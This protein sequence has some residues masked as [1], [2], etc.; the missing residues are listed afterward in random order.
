MNSHG[1]NSGGH[2]KVSTA[3]K[4]A[5]TRKW[6]FLAVFLLVLFTSTGVLGAL[7]LLPESGGTE[8]AETPKPALTAAASLA[9]A[10][11]LPTKI[12]IPALDLEV[13]V[14][15]PTSTNV[16]VL[17]KALLNGTVRYPT[18]SKL[19]EA[20]NVII[21]GHS[22]YLPIVRNPSFKAFNHIEDLKKGDRIL[23]T[24]GARTFVY[25]VESVLS[26]DAEED[27]IPL[28]VEGSKLTL[29]TCDSF[30]SKSDRFIVTANLVESYPAGI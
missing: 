21:F 11:E 23:V 20:G 8:V 5:L 15:N 7:D 13:D 27:A 30:G 14:A 10:P 24:G 9:M 18:S 3:A 4:K 22:S 1:H 2:G 19:G 12:E 17:D 25:E 6:S 16:A 26:A 29:A 28:T